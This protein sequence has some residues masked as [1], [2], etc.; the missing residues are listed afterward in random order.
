MLLF[1]CGCGE[2]HP[3]YTA[4]Q[5]VY[6]VCSAADVTAAVTSMLTETQPALRIRLPEG[7]AC[8][9]EAVICSAVQAN[10]L[11]RTMLRGVTWTQSD[12]YLNFHADYAK[13]AEILR[14]EK[15]LLSDT[16]EAWCSGNT[17]AP[18]AVRVLLAHDMLCRICDYD[19]TQ[20]ESHGA[21]GALLRHSAA[22]DGYAEA[23]AVLMEKA[24]IPVRILTGFAQIPGGQ[25]EP[26]AW[27]LVQLSGAWYHLDCTWDDS[28]D[29]P[30]HTYFL[31]DDE[32]MRQTHIW[33]IKKYP[34]ARGGGYRYE[35]IVTEMAALVREDGCGYNGYNPQQDS[36]R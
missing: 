3:E 16:A 23:F 17:G 22:C 19:D 36:D 35:E 11:A 31:C 34:P 25:H 18:D 6:P 5:A 1:C 21:C 26:H 32:A 12:G 29:V 13:P 10:V 2:K 33:D 14:A 30:Q 9:P 8:D 15:N 24:G 4:E 28:G 27:D 7:T 20:P